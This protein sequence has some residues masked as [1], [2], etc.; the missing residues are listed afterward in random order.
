M[1]YTT[2]KRSTLAL[3]TLYECSID[4]V[5]IQGDNTYDRQKV[6]FVDSGS[7]DIYVSNSETQPITLSKMILSDSN[8]DGLKQL[9]PIPKWL[10]LVQ[11]KG[12]STEITIEGVNIESKGSIE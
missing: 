2:T 5:G 11:N 9:G 12:T 4:F 8:I 10:A 1:P 3:G 6:L 7:V